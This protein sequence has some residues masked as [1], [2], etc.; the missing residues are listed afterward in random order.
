MKFQKLKRCI[1]AL[2]HCAYIFLKYILMLSSVMLLCSLL[3]F[4]FTANSN[5]GH[6][7]LAI[8]LLEAPAGVLLLGS[9][10][11]AFFMDRSL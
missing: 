8:Q 6:M 4:V 7:H 9:I 1:E 10:G 5:L 2:P 11:L 3:L